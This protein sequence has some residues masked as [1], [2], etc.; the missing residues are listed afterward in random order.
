MINLNTYIFEKLKI[1]KDTEIYIKGNLT[2]GYAKNLKEWIDSIRYEVVELKV[3]KDKKFLNFRD[4]L[5]S[6]DEKTNNP[7][8]KNVIELLNN[9][10]KNRP[11]II[12]SD[13]DIETD[14]EI[15]NMIIKGEEI[16]WDKKLN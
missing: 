15:F 14:K 16:K 7:I 1:D 3:N 13:N 5:S 2:L 12:G 10:V 11:E 6:I 9:Y 4:T 8:R